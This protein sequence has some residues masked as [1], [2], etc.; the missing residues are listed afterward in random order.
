MHRLH[1]GGRG[2]TTVDIIAATNATH[3]ATTFTFTFNSM[4]VGYFDRGRV[5]LE[6]RVYLQLQGLEMH[7]ARIPLKFLLVDQS[8]K[9]PKMTPI[10]LGGAK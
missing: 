7:A 9:V 4:R 5:Y 3:S 1:H 10:H 8:Y 6:G 2:Q